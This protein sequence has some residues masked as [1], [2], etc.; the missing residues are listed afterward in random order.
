MVRLCR[1]SFAAASFV[2]LL[3][4]VAIWIR[5]YWRD[6]ELLFRTYTIVPAS[7]PNPYNTD[8]FYRDE[9]PEDH[10]VRKEREARSDSERR[11]NC[12]YWISLAKGGVHLSRCVY[13]VRHYVKPPELKWDF[14]F[15]PE[16]YFGGVYVPGSF[17]GKHWGFLQVDEPYSGGAS[18]GARDASREWDVLFP[19]CPSLSCWR[20][21][22]RSGSQAFT[23]GNAWPPFADVRGNAPTAATIFAPAQ[24]AVPNVAA[25]R[26][27]PRPRRCPMPSKQ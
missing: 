24:S 10:E 2:L 5:G 16:L 3:A 20:S 13:D 25:W 8:D 4:T 18:G 23:A 19:L 1:R 21:R 11:T 14:D 12:E 26:W 6:D 27:L 17:D 9:R 7:T 15:G 22:R